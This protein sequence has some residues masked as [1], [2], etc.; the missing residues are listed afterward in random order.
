MP[1]PAGGGSKRQPC[2]AYE[3]PVSGGATK[4][5]VPHHSLARFLLVSR[6]GS[7]V[8]LELKL[9]RVASA[10]GR[11][12]QLAIGLATASSRVTGSR[13]PWRTAQRLSPRPPPD[14]NMQPLPW[15]KSPTSFELERREANPRRLD[16][17][18]ATAEAA[19]ARAQRSHRAHQL[20]TSPEDHRHPETDAHLA[21][22]H[23][24]QS[25]S[26]P[27][28][29]PVYLDAVTPSVA[30][31]PQLATTAYGFWSHALNVQDISPGYAGGHDY[32]TSLGGEF[33]FAFESP[34]MIAHEQLGPAPASD[35]RAPAHIPAE[36]PFSGGAQGRTIYSQSP[37]G[38]GLAAYALDPPVGD[39]WQSLGSQGRRPAGADVIA[40]HTYDHSLHKPG[41][42][43]GTS[44]FETVGS[45]GGVRSVV[46]F[47]SH[48][49]QGRPTADY[50]SHDTRLPY[51]VSILPPLPSSSPV[52]SAAYSLSPAGHAFA[53]LSLGPPSESFAAA[54]LTPQSEPYSYSLQCALPS[55]YPGGTSRAFSSGSGGGDGTGDAESPWP[56]DLVGYAQ[57]VKE[58][59]RTSFEVPPSPPADHFE[60]SSPSRRF[61]PY[62]F[63]AASLRGRPEQGHRGRALRSPEVHTAP[64]LPTQAT[65]VASSPD[66]GDDG[67]DS[68]EWLPPG[69][70]SR[71]RP[72]APGRRSSTGSNARARI[73]SSERGSGHSRSEGT[74]T[75]PFVGAAAAER[76]SPITGRPVKAIAKR[77]WPPK[78]AHKRRFVCDDCG[79]TCKFNEISS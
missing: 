35:W 57:H 16:I 43:A 9:A 29:D 67:R 33:E 49:S 65:S 77:S 68:P 74:Q 39:G 11:C 53:G 27:A 30:E 38:A 8:K 75:G 61:S 12:R 2:A 24:V 3:A 10:I 56:E 52:T 18:A 62:A 66:E 37:G 45:P 47:T 71:S 32:Q 6:G 76:I 78:D 44:F 20:A 28:R 46:D 7:R 42:H 26:G 31:P 13:R 17:P 21:R 58:E 63:H 25:G 73:S 41:G 60:A 55:S 69:P 54:D 79:K 23:S 64:Q 48:R 50:S 34:P 72:P 19:L 14:S 4:D 36:G 1:R 22:I 40:G 59:P 51:G 15:D 5:K 70:S